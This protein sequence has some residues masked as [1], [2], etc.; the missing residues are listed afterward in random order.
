MGTPPIERRPNGISSPQ[1]YGTELISAAGSHRKYLP[2]RRDCSIFATTTSIKAI[3][4]RYGN[5]PRSGFVPAD[6]ILLIMC[7]G[8]DV[9][10]WNITLI[11]SLAGLKPFLS[12]IA[13]FSATRILMLLLIRLVM[14][15]SWHEEKPTDRVNFECLEDRLFR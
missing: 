11:L 6:F 15:L 3:I 10:Q 9:S 1:I 5:W 8:M 4:R 7:Y 13:S 12:T 14:A 2:R